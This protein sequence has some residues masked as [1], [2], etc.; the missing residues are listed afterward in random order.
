MNKG[1]RERLGIIARLAVSHGELLEKGRPDGV[2]VA[3]VGTDH[4]YLPIILLEGAM[5]SRVVMTDL[6]KG[7]LSRAAEHMEQAGIDPSLYELRL[8]SGLEPL[9]R[10]EADTVVMAGMGGELIRD[11]LA[12]DI[13]KTRSFKRFVFQPRRRAGVLRRFL[14][15]NDI[16]ITDERVCVENGHYCQII[17]AECPR[18]ESFERFECGL[19][20]DYAP[21]LGSFGF[22]EGGAEAP[23]SPDAEADGLSRDGL[24]PGVLRGFFEELMRDLETV[25]ENILRSTDPERDA[26]RLSDTEARIAYLRRR[27]E[28]RQ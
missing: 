12:E 25:R 20:Y 2:L 4:G 6:R 15:E 17:A 1:I 11:L 3:D 18:P 13:T 23:D 27:T 21:M 10:G 7:P 26:S 19:D 22:G 5:C 16:Y 24:E 8:G 28:G 14:A 9:E